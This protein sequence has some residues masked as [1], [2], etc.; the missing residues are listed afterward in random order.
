MRWVLSTAFVVLLVGSFDA[1]APGDYPIQ[2]VPMS[3][4]RGR[5]GFGQAKS[6]TNRTVTIPH[7]LEQN[8]K[9]GRVDNLRKG[10][11]L[12]P[13]DY[14]GRRFNDTDIYKI[15]EA[16]SYSLISHPDPAL[17]KQLD[18]LVAIIAKAQRPAGPL[19]RARTINRAKPPRGGGTGG[20][21]Y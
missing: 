19:F 13:G 18:A 1:Q 8:E 10:A 21:Q 3:Q 2:P 9:T 15:V 20:G 5:G 16:A 14:V 11:G 17:A 6:E 7:I 4:G 12:M